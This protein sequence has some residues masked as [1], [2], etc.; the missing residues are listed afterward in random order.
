MII[1]AQELNNALTEY[2]QTFPSES[3]LSIYLAGKYSAQCKVEVHSSLSAAVKTTEDF[4]CAQ[5]GG[6][7]WSSEFE[8]ELFNHIFSKHPW[9]DMSGFS[10]LL[11]FS[12]WLC[13]H[14]GL[15]A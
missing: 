6:V 3:R 9:L 2:I 15:N 10:S 4:L 1:N 8:K 13:W 5:P 14:D 11:G 7:H 12:K